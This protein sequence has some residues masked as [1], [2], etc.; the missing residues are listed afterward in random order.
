MCGAIFRDRFA[1]QNLDFPLAAFRRQDIQCDPRPFAAYSG[2]I[3]AQDAPHRFHG[4][5]GAINVL[6]PRA[7]CQG[8]GHIAHGGL[9]AR[10]KLHQV[11]NDRRAQP[12][13]IGL[14]DAAAQ[15]GSE[16]IAAARD[17]IGLLPSK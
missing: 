5:E 4:Q 8:S 13:C 14:E 15:F 11:L 17:I 16:R 1:E 3:E 7:M 12:R 2:R 9:G 10:T 6:G